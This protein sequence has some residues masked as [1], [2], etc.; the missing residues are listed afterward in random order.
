MFYN[1]SSPNC[2]EQL[3]KLQ[4]LILNQQHLTTDT[5]DVPQNLTK[6]GLFT[7]KSAYVGLKNQPTFIVFIHRVWKMKVPPRMKVFGWLVY[8]KKILTA[9]NL[10]KRGWNMPSMC[11]LCREKEES[12]K[13]L[14]S[15]CTFSIQLYESL[16]R[17]MHLTTRRWKEI[18][19]EIEAPLWVVSKKGDLRTR[20]IL[21][22][23]LFICWRERCSRIFREETKTI[24]ELTEEVKEQWKYNQQ[25]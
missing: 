11:V 7:V 20:E 19:E 9:E 6:S 17:V 13:H 15:E 1:I 2:L 25:D 10:M 3:P 24:N 5:D 12:I 4:N 14:F 8:Y 23:A 18:L 22:I 21:L 16:S